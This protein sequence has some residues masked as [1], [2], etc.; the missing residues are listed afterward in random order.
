MSVKYKLEI[1]AV[2]IALVILAG[3]ATIVVLFY[4][5]SSEK[6]PWQPFVLDPPEYPG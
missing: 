1:S 6:T 4:E 2:V 5:A 3:I